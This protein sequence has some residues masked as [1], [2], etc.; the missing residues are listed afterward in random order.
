M[1]LAILLAILT[2]L[3]PNTA[4]QQPRPPLL[5]LG[6][7]DYPPLSYLEDGKAAG[8]EVDVAAA[9]SRAL[10]RPIHV[11]LMDW[12]LAQEKVLQGEADGLVDLG[13]TEERR[14][15]FAFS[16]SFVT[17]SYGLFVRSGPN[18][19]HGADELHGRRV[20]VTAG[21]LPRRHL[22]QHSDAELVLIDNYDDG[23]ERLS[24]GAIDAVAADTWVAAYTIER[25]RLRNITLAGVPFAISSAGIAVRKDHA[26]ELTA[27][28]LGLRRM[29]ADGTL[30]RI[31]ARWRPQEMMFLSRQ[32]FEWVVGVT[33]A[34]VVTLVLVTMALWVFTLKKQIR[35]RRAVEAELRENKER[36]D[37][38]LAA[39]EMGVWRWH[40]PTDDAVLDANLNRILGLDRETS[41]RALE[42]FLALAHPE[43]R[44]AVR[45]EID[46]AICERDGYSKEFRV[47]RTDGCVRWVRAR[48]RAFF[49]PSGEF[50]YL[51]GA[52]FDVTDHRQAEAAH[53][54]SEE[55]FTRAFRASPD[56]IAIS[57]MGPEGLLEV[58]DRFEEVTGYT[59]AEVLG[60]T[61][62][63]LGMVDAEIR[64]TWYSL[65]RETGRIRDFEYELRRKDGRLATLVMSAERIEVGGKPRVLSVSR[66]VTDRKLAEEALHRTEAKYRELVENANDIVFT[67]DPEGYCLSLNRAG[68]EISGYVGQQGPVHLKQLVSADDAET[69]S[70]HLQRVLAGEDVPVFEIDMLQRQG[71]RVRMEVS[72]RPIYEDGRPVAAQGIARD[73]T[74]RKELEQQLRQ[75]QKMDAV[76]RLAAGVAHDFNNLLTII[77]GN[78]E[79]GARRLAPE[80]PLR[81]TLHDIQTAADRAASLTGQL[82]AFSRRQIIQ[83]RPVDLNEVV[84]DIR[85]MI[86]RLIGEDINVQF[87]PAVGLWAVHA[88][89]GQLQQVIVNLCVNARDAMPH[90]GRLTIETRNLT[91][92]AAHVESGARVPAGDFVMLAVSDTGVGMDAETRERLFEPFFTTKAAG[93]GTGLGLATVYGIV[94][95]G[96]GFVFVDSQPGAGAAFRVLL[97]RTS[98]ERVEP[99]L[100]TP[101]EEPAGGHETVMLV[102][103][104]NDVR[105]LFS[106]FLT[107]QGYRV[108]A[109]RSADAALDLSRGLSTAP[110]LLVTDIVMPGMNGR[111][112]ADQLRSSYP[113]LKV[114][115]VSGYT[116]DALIRRGVLP[117][118]TDFLQK[119]FSLAALAKKL[120]DL[121]DAA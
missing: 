28:N 3:P 45:A 43:D 18:S 1:A 95:Q 14:Q 37:V 54:D 102:E 116:D 6:D 24:S 61:I 17:H 94:K 2:G 66:D 72:V 107:S 13:M 41:P 81:A 7:K 93:K 48:G 55:K 57:D 15:K 98:V 100:E 19:L 25:H 21:G 114:L 113:R 8:F 56:A 74:A 53:R 36:L 115:Y 12:R 23:F 73:V 85:R 84:A 105:E 108:V 99:S 118:G 120:R 38:A 35:E 110:A 92:D 49:A 47:I 51:A 65:L 119:P 34:G 90:G 39:G 83:P 69:A 111:A 96:G 11:V 59:R 70:R 87:D 106:D 78:C 33:A 20:G 97:P 40:G 29:K 44:V 77:L 63:D 30:A 22:E 104:E 71:T 52:A 10:G 42:A 89:P 31:Q 76:G 32:R 112:L 101:R 75:A 109:A 67:V 9:L 121:V 103:D 80:D 5:L 117:S 86:T 91:F 82:L 4:Q 68:R 62:S 27:I 50:S 58:N 64:Q 26:D 88:D 46:R 60:R 16:D 79:I